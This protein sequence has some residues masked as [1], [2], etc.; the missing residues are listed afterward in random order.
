[1]RLGPNGVQDNP[2][3][4]KPTWLAHSEQCWPAKWVGMGSN[5]G[6]TTNQGHKKS[7]K[8]MQ[9]VI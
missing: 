9:A 1:M 4:R 2:Y 7:G 5:P 8:I 6:Q 3:P